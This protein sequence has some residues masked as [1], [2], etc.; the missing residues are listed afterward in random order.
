MVGRKLGILFLAAVLL[1]FLTGYFA[2][3][4]LPRQLFRDP[5]ESFDLVTDA[6]KSRYYYEIDQ[7]SID[8]AYLDSLRAIVDSYATQNNDPYTRLY[9]IPSIT[10]YQSDEYYIGI[11]IS[12]TYED[13]YLRIQNVDRQSDAYGH[14][15][16]NDLIIGVKSNSQFI[17]FDLITR[18]E[19]LDYIQGDLGETITLVY[20]TPDQIIREIDV[21][22]KQIDTPSVTTMDLGEED[23]AY[24]KIHQF[25][26]AYDELSPGTSFLFKQALSEIENEIFANATLDDTLI[27][28]LRD[29]P[30]GALT[31]LHNSGDQNTIPGIVQDLLSRNDDQPLFSMI[32]RNIDERVDFYSN[33][34][35][36]R[37]Y[38]IA[39]L[40]NENSA[41]AAEV[42]AATLYQSAGYLLYGKPTYGKNVYQTSITLFEYQGSSYGLTYTEGMWTYG[43][44]LNVKDNPLP[45]IEINQSGIRTLDIP[46]YEGEVELN[47]VSLP[48]S[49]YQKLYNAYYMLN[50]TSSIRTDGYFDSATED[51]M[52]TIQMDFGLDVTGKLDRD[53]A[54]ALF[55][56]YTESMYDLTYDHQLNELITRLNS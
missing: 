40:V 36:L 19:M 39:V 21:T 56:L 54:I 49:T 32:P 55:D 2:K 43:N 5:D 35:E 16:P 33:R 53:T 42:L 18:E 12:L 50:E 26:A 11:G 15:I 9:E 3:D 41:S 28:D 30:G 4:L 46:F 20:K 14:I 37:D 23:L 38:N 48:L 31:A 6:L 8:I 7:D 52:E 44:E 25:H 47:E 45:V 34:L 24:I 13:N 22:I 1:A 27:I 29:N 51:A 10:T 17:D